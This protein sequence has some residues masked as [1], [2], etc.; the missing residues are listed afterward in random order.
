MY[1]L[2][3]CVDNKYGT[4][5]KFK[6]DSDA[7]DKS[8]K[9]LVE[10]LNQYNINPSDDY[11]HLYI[12]SMLDR[13]C[14]T[15][16]E[17]EMFPMLEQF[18]D[19]IYQLAVDNMLFFNPNKKV[20]HKDE[21]EYV[22]AKFQ[23]RVAEKFKLN[24]L[25]ISALTES[26]NS[27][28]ESPYLNDGVFVLDGGNYIADMLEMIIGSV[29]IEF[30][31]QKALDFATQLIHNYDKTLL[32]PLFVKY[33]P[34][35]IY[36]SAIKTEYYDKIFPPLLDPITD[37][38]D[39]EYRQLLIPITKI[40]LIK[41]FGNDTREKRNKIKFSYVD[42]DYELLVVYLYQGIEKAIDYYA[43]KCI[44]ENAHIIDGE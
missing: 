9:K 31:T 43:C 42:F 13:K 29:G 24:E 15:I 37:E 34:Y 5:C 40:V 36:N 10:F 4:H 1:E 7:R 33:D 6:F 22:N 35:E 16:D 39:K 2:L 23:R 28:Y 44:K 3:D 20:N 11:K 26:F 30:G 32:M 12:T 38:Y 19:A 27:K 18:G 25:Y 21:E 17:N 14:A 41:F 8:Y